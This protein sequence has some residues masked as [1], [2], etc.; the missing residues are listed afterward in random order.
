M[1]QKAPYLVS[2]LS[3]SARSYLDTNK[4]RMLRPV[5][6]VVDVETRF[7]PD[8]TLIRSSTTA[9]VTMWVSYEIWLKLVQS[10]R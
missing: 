1:P 4:Q 3:R 5:S 8:V 2:L 10:V 7:G 6:E 9:G